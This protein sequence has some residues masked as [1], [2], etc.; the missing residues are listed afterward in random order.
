METL[1]DLLAR[2][3]RTDAVAVRDDGA[4][5]DARTDPRS[6]DPSEG[7]PAVSYTYHDYVTTAWKTANLFSHRGVHR[8]ATVAVVDDAAV[9][10]LLAFLGAAQLGALTR[11]DPPESVEADLLVGPGEAVLS[12]DLPPGGTRLAYTTGEPVADPT[13]EAFGPSVWSENPTE[14]PEQIEPGATALWTMDGALSHSDLLARA[15][16]AATDLVPGDDVV[17]RAPLAS[18]GAVVVGVLAPLLA[19]ASVVLPAEG[20][21]GDVAVVEAESEAF[22]AP[23][24]CSVV[25]ED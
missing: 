2:E 12:A 20:T 17:V 23:E 1:G 18:V 24:V 5:G 8:G 15:E 9:P 21:V 19:G 10:P 7:V 6:E 16:A 25:V 11:F 4:T 22:E 14:P 3:R 13:V